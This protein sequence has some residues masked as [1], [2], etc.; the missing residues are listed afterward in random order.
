MRTRAVPRLRADHRA[1]ARAALASLASTL[2]GACAAGCVDS[3]APAGESAAALAPDQ[4]ARPLLDPRVPLP[5]R[6]E[7]VALADEV[8]VQAEQA[9]PQVAAGIARVAADLR[10][11]LWRTEHADADV[12][13][14]L[15]LYARIAKQA[16]APAE[17]TCDALVAHASL[18]AEVARDPGVFALEAN[19]A[20][21]AAPSGPCAATFRAKLALV[22]GWPPPER[23]GGTHGTAPA[24]A[25]AGSAIPARAIL[26]DDPGVVVSPR[27]DAAEGATLVGIETYGSS[28][29]AARIVVTLSGPTPFDVAPGLATTADAGATGA[30]LDVDLPRLVAKPQEIAVGGLVRSVR[31]ERRAGEGARV[32]LDLASAVH[33]RVFFLPEPFRV[34]IDVSTRPPAP[35]LAAPAG[36]PRPVARVVLDPG[37]GGSDPGAIGPGGL[38]EKDVTLDVAH[39]AA[40]VLARELGIVTLLTRDDDRFIPLD[41]RTARANA[42]QADLFVSIHCNSE[43]RGGTGRGVMSFVLDTTRDEVASRVAARENAASAAANAQVAWMVANLRLADLGSRSTRLAEL[44]QKTTMASLGPRWRD[45]AD[46][47]VKTATFFVLVGADMPSVLFETSFISHPVEETRLAT[48]EYRQKLA[49]AIVNAVRAYRE[50]R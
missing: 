23:D 42:F 39:R 18:A 22:P 1:L 12:R 44:L 30:R 6:A 15:E 47:G 41:E 40:P 5:P 48:A 17:T 9:P 45:V 49:D 32:S 34:V 43:P 20:L 46:H 37:H 8:A 24:A 27:I 13:E 35:M 11:R 21:A 28:A 14:A 36:S 29:E 38:R 7:V 19:R 33:H 26:P 25:A 50:G 31:V 4:R 2:L 3:A 16:G 10:A